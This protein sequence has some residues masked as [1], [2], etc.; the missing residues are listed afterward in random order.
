MDTYPIYRSV[1][2]IH[3]AESKV[4]RTDLIES[5]EMNVYAQLTKSPE[6]IAPTTIESVNPT[7]D[8]DVIRAVDTYYDT[9]E[10]A[11]QALMETLRSN[12]MFNIFFDAPDAIA[13]VTR[14]M[15]VLRLKREQMFHNWSADEVEEYAPYWSNIIDNLQTFC[16]AT[17]LDEIMPSDDDVA[18]SEVRI[19]NIFKRL[20]NIRNEDRNRLKTDIQNVVND[21]V[22]SGRYNDITTFTSRIYAI[23]TGIDILTDD[24]GVDVDADTD[25]VIQTVRH[26]M[27]KRENEARKTE[28]ERLNAE[29]LNRSNKG[30]ENLKEKKRREDQRKRQ[31]T[32]RSSKGNKQNSEGKVSAKAN[33]QDNKKTSGGNGRKNKRQRNRKNNGR[34]KGNKYG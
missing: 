7:V 5:K 31:G 6:R 24:F 3:M 23:I 30:I 9:L 1:E 18:V 8:I 26:I 12:D 17:S 33:S 20:E 2:Y 4:E 22:D 16:E 10:S 11:R 21:Y 15:A 19:N 27:Q 32:G 14:K 29:K 34:Q 13:R 25:Y 28:Q